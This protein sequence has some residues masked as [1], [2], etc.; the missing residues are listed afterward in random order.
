MKHKIK[1]NPQATTEEIKRRK[2]TEELQKQ[3]KP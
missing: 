2:N 3:T 1:E